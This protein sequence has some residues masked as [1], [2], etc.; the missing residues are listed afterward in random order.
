MDCIWTKSTYST[1]PTETCP[2]KG[3]LHCERCQQFADY[4]MEAVLS[5]PYL[6][7]EGKCLVD[8]MASCFVNWELI[9]SPVFK[10]YIQTWNLGDNLTEPELFLHDWRQPQCWNRIYLM[11]ASHLSNCPQCLI[12]QEENG[13]ACMFSREVQLFG[14]SSG[15]FHQC[16]QTKSVHLKNYFY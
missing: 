16:C 1:T 10:G 12:L 14:D 13:H 6:Q 2:K 7:R 8:L 5:D 11:I 3:V 15:D 4:N 9:F